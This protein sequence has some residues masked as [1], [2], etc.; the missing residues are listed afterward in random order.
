ML[1]FTFR[2]KNRD[3]KYNVTSLIPE[4]FYGLPLSFLRIDIDIVKL[5]LVCKKGRR[6]VRT[7]QEKSC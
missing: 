1:D 7:K 6:D 2:Y 5:S 3:K 4:L